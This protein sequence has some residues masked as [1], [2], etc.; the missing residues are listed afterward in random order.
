MCH[1]NVC[2][3]TMQQA[4]NDS[5]DVFRLKN[6][7]LGLSGDDKK[8]KTVRRSHINTVVESRLGKGKG[9]VD[10]CSAFL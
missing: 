2:S 8:L 9:K 4:N 7:P 5:R 1:L 3:I 6:E 10:L